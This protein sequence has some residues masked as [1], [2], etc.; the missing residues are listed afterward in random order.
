MKERAFA[1]IV[2][3]FKH[4]KYDDEYPVVLL[5]RKMLMPKKYM[6]WQG[7]IGCFGGALEG[8]ETP[9]EAIRRELQEELDLDEQNLTPLKTVEERHYFLL[10]KKTTFNQDAMTWYA[11]MCR[12]GLLD[13]F[14]S[15]RLENEDKGNFIF[16]EIRSIALQLLMGK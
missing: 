9:L 12:E 7:K 15:F 11:G 2:A 16:P 13:V 3:N 5:N 6:E 14:D 1:F 8:H 4:K 10:K